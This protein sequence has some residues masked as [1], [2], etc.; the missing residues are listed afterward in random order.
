[1]KKENTLPWLATVALCLEIL[2]F[3][4]IYSIFDIPVF[5]GLPSTAVFVLAVVWLGFNKFVKRKYL[6]RHAT[7]D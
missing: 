6:K 7:E 5:I 3:F 1:M 4:I 2:I